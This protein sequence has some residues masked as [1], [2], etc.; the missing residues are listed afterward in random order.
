MEIIVIGLILFIVG[1]GSTIVWDKKKDNIKAYIK[2]VSTRK[3]VQ[4]NNTVRGNMSRKDFGKPTVNPKTIPRKKSDQEIAEEFLERFKQ[5]VNKSKTA[6]KKAT[7]K[8]VVRP[9]PGAIKFEQ[10]IGA[11]GLPQEAKYDT[12]TVQELQDMLSG[13]KPSSLEDRVFARKAMDD[14]DSAMKDVEQSLKDMEKSLD[15]SFRKL[16]NEE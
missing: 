10:S 7:T 9:R 8:K 14:I 11:L 4:R 2:D 12:Y 6:A 5:Q 3:V 1:V 15:D 16:F 13:K